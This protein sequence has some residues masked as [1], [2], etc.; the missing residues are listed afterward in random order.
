MGELG[1][2]PSIYE[3]VELLMNRL[4]STVAPHMHAP[5]GDHVHRWTSITTRRPRL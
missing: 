3:L 2:Q 4:V 5:A 1:G